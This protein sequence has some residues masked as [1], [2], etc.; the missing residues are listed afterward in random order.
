[1]LL[2]WDHFWQRLWLQRA[3]QE[4]TNVGSVGSS[5]R[6]SVG[7]ETAQVLLTGAALEH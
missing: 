2:E 7:S 4:N 1:M 6:L 5:V 3:C